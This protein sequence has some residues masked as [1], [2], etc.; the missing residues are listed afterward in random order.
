MPPRRPQE[1][2]YT[3]LE[4]PAPGPRVIHFPEDQSY[5]EIVV[6]D[7]GSPVHGG[8]S[9]DW[10]DLGF[11]RAAEA[12]GPVSIPEAQEAGLA[13][14]DEVE[15]FGEGLR[16]LQPDDLQYVFTGWHNSV[17]WTDDDCRHLSRL[18]GLVWVSLVGVSISDEGLRWLGGMRGVRHFDLHRIPG[19]TDEGIAHLSGLTKIE[20]FFCTSRRITD[21]SMAVFGGWG[22]SL[23]QIR[24][25]SERITD[26]GMAHMARCT[27]LENMFIP[28]GVTWR[29]VAELHGKPLK[30][31]VMNWGSDGGNRN[32]DDEALEQLVPLWVRTPTLTGLDLGMT[33]ITDAGLRLLQRLKQLDWIYVGDNDGVT[34]EG[35]AA[36][37][38]A[39]P[40]VGGA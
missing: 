5:G 22:E 29:G 10:K 17:T 13:L 33:A 15:G 34:E 14:A 4:P 25:S 31:I 19:L 6:R 23:L 9:S 27:R 38:A 26:G 21:S 37:E 40:K 18:Q 8:Y 3:S 20:S 24:L 12:R 35:I 39:L 2:L 7:W 11:R 36:L 30:T 32:I 28:W 16:L 1:T